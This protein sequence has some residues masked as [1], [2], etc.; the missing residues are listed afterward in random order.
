MNNVS[1]IRAWFDDPVG[2]TI[3]QSI[4]DKLMEKGG[5]FSNDDA[6]TEAIGM[7]TLSF[8]MDL[9]L[10]NFL[11]FQEKALSKP[12]DDVVDMLLEQVHGVGHELESKE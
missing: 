5:L 12:V 2:K 7:D 1:T 6:S 11:R 10:R 4:F 9:P 3:L 8:L